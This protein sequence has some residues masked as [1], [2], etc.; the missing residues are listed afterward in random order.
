MLGVVV[1]WK[2]IT[3]IKALFS[4]RYS[5]ISYLLMASPGVNAFPLAIGAEISSVFFTTICVGNLPPTGT[6]G[7]E[8]GNIQ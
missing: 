3:D 1:V 6:H 7:R 5:N 8:G 2:L 4:S